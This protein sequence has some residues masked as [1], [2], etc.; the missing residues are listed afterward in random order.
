MIQS[1][2]VS[3][4]AQANSRTLLKT[5]EPLSRFQ[6]HKTVEFDK[7]FRK[8]DKRAQ[9]LI[10]QKIQEVLFLEPYESKR[11]VSPQFKG[12]RSLRSG[13]FRI[14]FAIC[15]ECKLFHEDRIN[16]CYDCNRYE[17]NNVMLFLCAHRK[18]AYDT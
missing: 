16:N 10:D 12:K 9:K 14:I 15:A 6:C 13:D 1:V 8:L 17:S 5:I 18:H 11:L 4:S 3:E 7:S 2:N